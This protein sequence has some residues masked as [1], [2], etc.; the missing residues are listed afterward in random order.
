MLEDA[1][2]K[3]FSNEEDKTAYF[4]DG[5]IKIVTEW[6]HLQ[7]LIRSTPG[8]PENPAT[9][10]TI[11]KLDKDYYA[12]P[13][14][15]GFSIPEGKKIILDLNG[16]VIDRGLVNPK[17]D[18]YIGKKEDSVINVS[19]EL[20]I[21]DSRP[22]VQH[23]GYIDKDGIWNIGTDGHPI[24]GENI[25]TLK[26]GIITGGTGIL[27]E[28]TGS[29]G[30][31]ISI[32]EKGKVV[33]N[34]GTIA[35]NTAN[36]GGAIHNCNYFEM[37][38]GLIFA[39]SAQT[40]GGIYN[41]TS[42]KILINGGTIS[43]NRA[44]SQSGG[45]E[46]DLLSS[47][48]MTNGKI[49]NNYAVNNNSMAGGICAA[50]SRELKDAKVELCTKKA[51][52]E[53]VITGNM[54]NGNVAG[55]FAGNF[56][57]IGGKVIIKDNKS[58]ATDE[59]NKT[60]AP[61]ANLSVSDI[62]KVIAPLKGA[63][64]YITR[65]T[66][67]GK[68]HTTGQLTS[69]YVYHNQDAGLN[70]F[71]HYDGP[72]EFYMGRNENEELVVYEVPESN[73]AVQIPSSVGGVVSSDVQFAK[74][75]DSVKLTAKPD[76]GYMLDKL[77]VTDEDGEDVKVTLNSFTMPAKAVT[78]TATFK[79]KPIQPAPTVMYNVELITSDHGLVGVSPSQVEEGGTVTIK[80]TP[81]KGYEID[82]IYVNGEE[83]ESLVIENVS[84]DIEVEVTF[85][86]I[87]TEPKWTKSAVKKAIGKAKIKC[88][89]KTVK[90]GTRV[91]VFVK[92][93]SLKA[94]KAAGYKVSYK[95]Y[96]SLKKHTSFKLTKTTKKTK[97]IQTKGKKGKYYYY[98]VK[99]IVKDKAGK[100]VAS[101]LLKNC[102]Y[103]K[104]KFYR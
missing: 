82:K 30:G 95:F 86:K 16:H 6:T 100:V 34:G 96:R 19:G 78:V 48:Q 46:L 87:Q 54:S 77:T 3:F 8:T 4:E 102:R 38:K 80:A 67:I 52:D 69:S 73:Y 31:G 92:N 35:G 7:Y 42:A 33:L 89:T 94:I 47:L 43:T 84:S 39:N 61:P 51:S 57:K 60:K 104:R 64:I 28:N 14:E 27:T 103:G 12:I 59:E 36:R 18:I 17:E 91:K 10:P 83:V 88:R 98:R 62:V 44:A 15:E 66:S 22:N 1:L 13:E 76:S 101:T 93:V 68:T 97:Y 23:E 20:T 56:L 63:C 5:F 72:N 75:G 32:K 99:L 85:K 50:V 65:Q 21:E 74:S 11:I 37:N 55:I 49:V 41:N 2:K 29:N 79:K 53:I 90:K 25:Q 45:I 24:E 26:G 58:Y 9:E 81:D 40:G 70:D 71:F